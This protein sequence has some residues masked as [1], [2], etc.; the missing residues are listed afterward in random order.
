[1][2]GTPDKTQPTI[3]RLADAVSLDLNDLRIALLVQDHGSFRAASSILQ[4]RPSVVSRRIRHLEDYIGVGLFQRRSRGVILTIAGRR[5]LM[6]ASA[7]MADVQSL[8]QTASLAGSGNEGQ[9]CIGL[10]SSIAGGSA[11]ELLTSFMAA[12][13]GVTLNL[14]DGLSQ[15]H[16]AAVRGLRMDVALVVDSPAAPGCV[17]EPLWAEPIYVAV[18]ANSALA[19]LGELQWDHIASELFIVSIT[20]HG[21]DIQDIVMQH[22]TGTRRRPAVERRPVQRGGLLGLVSLGVG[23]SLVGMAEAAVTYPDV[24]FRPLHGE[25][26]PFSAVWADNNDNPVLRRFLSLARLQMRTPASPAGAGPS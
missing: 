13:S 22:L 17:V 14:V 19:E 16:I 26:L 3:A 1:M 10:V 4:V 25:M 6:Q 5:I 2:P 11:R 12:H 18:S 24:V 9:I 21:T 20:G 8:V 7:I 15:D 23:I